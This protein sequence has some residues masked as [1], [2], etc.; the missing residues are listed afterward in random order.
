MRNETYDEHYINS[1]TALGD[2]HEVVTTQ[3]VF[4][5]NGIKLDQ[6]TRINSA[7][8]DKLVQHKLIPSIDVCLSTPDGVTNAGLRTRARE[9]LDSEPR[10]TAAAIRA[11]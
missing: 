6:G 5:R 10:S 2:T 9:I 8:R 1:V 7:L 3:A 4:T 11:G